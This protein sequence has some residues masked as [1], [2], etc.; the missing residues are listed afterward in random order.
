[1]SSGFSRRL[2]SKAWELEIG[3]WGVRSIISIP[4]KRHISAFKTS[5]L[6]P[7]SSHEKIAFLVLFKVKKVT[8]SRPN[9]VQDSWATSRWFLQVCTLCYPSPEL[10][11]TLSR[12]ALDTRET[13]SV[14]MMWLAR[15][16]AGNVHRVNLLLKPF[17]RVTYTPR[18]PLGSWHTLTEVTKEIYK[19]RANFNQKFH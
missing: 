4:L 11:V 5:Q 17:A 7:F 8:T 3:I 9:W 6:S 13:G 2:S 1:M 12:L 16:P 19:K 14:D 10:P 18:S 15:F